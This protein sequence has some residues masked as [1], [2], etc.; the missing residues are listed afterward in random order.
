M[1][2]TRGEGVYTV[3]VEDLR[4]ALLFVRS[5]R[6]TEYPQRVCIKSALH[7]LDGNAPPKASTAAGKGSAGRF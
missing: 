1:L 6:Q 4:G 5:D 2:D 3:G 7:F